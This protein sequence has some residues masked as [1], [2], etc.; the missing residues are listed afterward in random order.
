MKNLSKFQQTEQKIQKPNSIVDF[1]KILK[2]ASKITYEE[3][4]ILMDSSVRGNPTFNIINQEFE[5][6]QAEHFNDVKFLLKFK[7][8][9]SS[10]Q[11]ANRDKQQGATQPKTEKLEVLVKPLD[12]QVEEKVKKI[13]K[14]SPIKRN[15]GV[16]HINHP[17]S[18]KTIDNNKNTPLAISQETQKNRQ[19]GQFFKETNNEDDIIIAGQYNIKW[20][21]IKEDTQPISLNFLLNYLAPDKKRDEELQNAII[22]SITSKYKELKK[23][24]SEISR[25]LILPSSQEFNLYTIVSFIRSIL[26]NMFKICDFE[27]TRIENSSISLFRSHSITIASGDI[28]ETGRVKKNLEVF[29]QDK[30]YILG[31]QERDLINDCIIGEIPQYVYFMKKAVEG[32]IFLVYFLLDS[33]SKQMADF[34]FENVNGQKFLRVFR[35][36]SDLIIK[37]LTEKILDKQSFILKLFYIVEEYLKLQKYILVNKFQ[38]S[39]KIL[40]ENQLYLHDNSEYDKKKQNYPKEENLIQHDLSII[41]TEFKYYTFIDEIQINRS[42]HYKQF[43][44]VMTQVYHKH[45]HAVSRQ[46]ERYAEWKMTLSFN[47]VIYLEFNKQGQ[48]CFINQQLSTT[49]KKKHKIQ[50]PENQQNI[51]YTDIFKENDNLLQ[52]IKDCYIQKSYYIHKGDCSSEDVEDNLQYQIIAQPGVKNKIKIVKMNLKDIDSEEEIQQKLYKIQSPIFNS[53]QKTFNNKIRN[54]L[55][56]FT[57]S[58]SKNIILQDNEAKNSTVVEF[59]SQVEQKKVNEEQKALYLKKL[60]SPN[61]QQFKRNIKCIA[62]IGNQQEKGNSYLNRLVQ[63]RKVTEKACSKSEILLKP[64]DFKIDEQINQE[65]EN[66]GIDIWKYDENQKLKIAWLIMEKRNYFK[67]YEIP[68]EEF[69]TFLYK[70]REKYNKRENPFHNFD[71]G[72]M[73]MHGCFMI[74]CRTNANKY[75]NSI[76]EFSL[77]FSGLCHDVSHRGKTNAFE[78]NTMSKLAIRYHDQ[79][80]LEQHHIA[81]TF[82]ILRQSN[83]NIFKNLTIQKVQQIRRYVINNILATDMSKHFVY[84]KDFQNDFLSEVHKKESNQLEEV[85]EAH[86]KEQFQFEEKEINLLTGTIIHTSDFH[87]TAQKFEL[88]KQW[89]VKVNKEFSQQYI[90]EGKQGVQQTAYLKDLDKMHVLAKNEAGFIKMIVKPLWETMNK[91]LNDQ[92]LEPVNNLENSILEWNKIYEKALQEEEE[93]QKQQE[94]NKLLAQSQSSHQSGLNAKLKNLI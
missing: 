17:T 43:E 5:R 34:L 89:S 81:H 74:G 11:N 41:G 82:K 46:L 79:S 47:Q 67:E 78:V 2:A 53:C 85:Q 23:N 27:V 55:T 16:I 56:Y 57:A 77:V 60:A 92:L 86:K 84:L 90:E 32:K 13:E 18:L 35:V 1:I 12:Q 54:K 66:F 3:E 72:I 6:E 88:S 4:I 28:R 9:L 49:L 94:I 20:N 26:K 14:G 21:K 73:V 76:Q 63:I 65:L 33:E 80:V 25:Y 62:D 40:F 50:L 22:Q 30:L 10:M 71:H 51:H 42:P 29:E 38:E 64:E 36:V 15:S 93:N 37:I 45:K 19:F 83:A 68:M 70:L 52:N 31:N 58:E 69:I 61:I 7:N 87:H 59:L 44:N 48:L 91:F 24:I 8:F 75:L 39:F